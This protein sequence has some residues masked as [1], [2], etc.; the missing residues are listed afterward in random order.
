MKGMGQQGL[1]F[2]KT[3]GFNVFLIDLPGFSCEEKV[4]KTHMIKQIM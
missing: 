2:K 4:K 3:R 1:C